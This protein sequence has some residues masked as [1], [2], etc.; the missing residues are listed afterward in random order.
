[1]WL[2]DHIPETGYSVSEKSEVLSSVSIDD[3]NLSIKIQAEQSDGDKALLYTVQDTPDEGD[4]GRG[5]KGPHISDRC[6]GRLGQFCGRRPAL[7]P[8]ATPLSRI[9]MRLRIESLGRSRDRTLRSI[10]GDAV[11]PTTLL[12]RCPVG[13][14]G[15]VIWYV[16][17]CVEDTSGRMLTLFFFLFSIF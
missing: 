12:R 6:E 4:G 5:P 15:S 9:P 17:V 1:M 13:D 7:I 3:L 10:N 14:V 2:R 8:P 16:C 11:R